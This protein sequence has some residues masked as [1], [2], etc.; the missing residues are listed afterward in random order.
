MT[1]FLT[2]EELDQMVMYS[3][4]GSRT[5]KMALE[6]LER[7]RADDALARRA[8]AVEAELSK[9]RKMLR[10][11]WFY[12]ADCHDSEKCCF[13][14]TEVLEE[15]YFYDRPR[16]G[17]HVV[18]ISCATSLP[19][20]WAAVRVDCKCTDEDDCDCDTDLIVTEHDSKEA[21]EAALAQKGDA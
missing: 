2:D 11:E 16:K 15:H 6:L 20:I 10:P 13:D 19:D 8:E 17:N 1:D 12:E 4:T 9:L 5:E 21:A 14:L 7:R 18:Q 3:V